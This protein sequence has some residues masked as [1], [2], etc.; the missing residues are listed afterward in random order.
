M[1]VVL[2]FNCWTAFEGGVTQI[3]SWNMYISSHKS[4]GEEMSKKHFSLV[5]C[6]LVIV[7]GDDWH[8]RTIEHLINSSHASMWF[9]DLIMR[10]L[11]WPLPIGMSNKE[12]NHI[13]V[14]F[15]FNVL[16]WMF[17]LCASDTTMTFQQTAT[18]TQK[19]TTFVFITNNCQKKKKTGPI[20]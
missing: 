7:V 5:M 10:L 18:H 9:N 8:N 11:K 19:N 1:F 13:L 6:F 15:H 16:I 4:C 2:F 17:C 20:T 14:L 12:E 3:E